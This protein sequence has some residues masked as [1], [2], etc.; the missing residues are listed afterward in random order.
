MTDR[1]TETADRLFYVL[2][3][4]QKSI[5]IAFAPSS[6]RRMRRILCRARRRCTRPGGGAEHTRERMPILASLTPRPAVSLPA[7]VALH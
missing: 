3:Q 6:S 5:D 4:I 1:Q 7:P 2:I